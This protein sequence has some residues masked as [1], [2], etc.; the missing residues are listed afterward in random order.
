LTSGCLLLISGSIADVIGGKKV[1][2]T[3][4][5]LLGITTVAC[6]VCTSGIQ[7]I[8][9]RA[10]QGV[11]LSLILPSMV[12]VI[13]RSIPTGTYRNIA[14]ASLG[15]G[16]PLGYSIGL[17]TGGI[18]VQTIGWRYGYYIGAIITFIVFIVSIYGVPSDHPTESQS[19]SSLWERLKSEID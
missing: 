9:F 2:L 15:A 19:L 3:G 16:Q 6:G 18:F 12:I 1:Y 10:I 4:L 17:V 14:F 11:A 5:F 7:L 8:L 13:T